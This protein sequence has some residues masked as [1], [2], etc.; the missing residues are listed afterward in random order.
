MRYDSY[1]TRA[2]VRVRVRRVSFSGIG[3]LLVVKP[4]F[5]PIFFS[6]SYSYRFLTYMCICASEAFGNKQEKKSNFN[7]KR[8]DFSLFSL[9]LSDFL[10]FFLS[11]SDFLSRQKLLRSAHL[12]Q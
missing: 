8:S 1:V 7:T 4:T 5:K 10:S 3:K 11:L 6:W 12:R 9:S 2:R